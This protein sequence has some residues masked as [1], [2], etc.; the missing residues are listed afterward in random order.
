MFKTSKPEIKTVK[1]WTNDKI[2]ELKG[3]F[4]WTDWDIFFEN[5]DVDS[6]TDAITDN[7]A[8][9]TDSIIPQVTVKRYQNNKPFFDRGVS[10][11]LRR[12]KAAFKAGDSSGVK[13]AQKDLNRQLR[14]ARSRHREQAEDHLATSNTKK[15]WDSIKHMPNMDSKRKPLC[16]QDELARANELNN[17]YMRFDTDTVSE[18]NVIL[19]NVECDKDSDRILIDA[20]TVTKIFRT[21]R[22]NKATG[23]DNMSAFLLKTFAEELTPA[24]HKLFQLSVDTS[25]VPV[26]WKQSIIIPV[27]KTMIIDQ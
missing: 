15:L 27:P 21:M 5:S 13:I 7:I 6:A 23:P 11:C 22:T 10:E 17:F 4:L 20:Q 24:W 16:G 18:C 25:T 12:K 26:R 2:E 9:C 8:L 14:A 19:N 3:C 1:K